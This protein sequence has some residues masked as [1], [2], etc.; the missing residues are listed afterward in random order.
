MKPAV[1]LYGVPGQYEN[2][3]AALES[4]GARVVLCRDLYRSL[5]CGG[6]LLPGGGDIRGIC[7][8]TN[9]PS[10]MDSTPGASS[11]TL[12]FTLVKLMPKFRSKSLACR[13]AALIES[14]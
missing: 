10:I 12:L 1:Y 2:Y 5:D 13:I 7:G 11:I 4:A 14:S 6:L 8:S 3:L 9:P